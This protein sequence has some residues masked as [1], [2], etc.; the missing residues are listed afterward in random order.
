MEFDDILTEMSGGVLVITLNRPQTLNALSFKTFYEL[1]EAIR[2]ADESDEVKCLIVTGSGRGFCAGLDMTASEETAQYRYLPS[3]S[4]GS[5]RP[6]DDFPEWIAACRKPLLTAINGVAVG[7]GF[8]LALVGDIRIAS[9]EARFSTIFTKRG[10]VVHAGLS[11]Y[12]PRIVGSA[13]A[14][15]LIWSSEFVEAG[16]ALA[17]GIVSRVVPAEELLPTALERAQE[18]ASGPSIAINLGKQLVYD[19]LTQS[20][21]DALHAEG[22]ALTITSHS[23]DSKEGTRAFLERR[24]P[25]FTGR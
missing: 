12:L 3:R 11:Y 2:L 6:A 7:A 19:S 10:R 23:E 17:S 13:R 24:D 4:G 1:S 21:P 22:R 9:E 18:V 15:E 25:V 16:E 20:L 5:Q 8:T 14:F